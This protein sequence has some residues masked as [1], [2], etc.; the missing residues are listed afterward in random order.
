MDKQEIW[1]AAEAID[2]AER[3]MRSAEEKYLR[4]CGW[5]YT[6]ATPGHF[7]MWQRTLGDGRTLIAERETALR[8]AATMNEPPDA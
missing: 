8:F 2:E 6:C 3:R 5:E 4:K 1:S 7:W